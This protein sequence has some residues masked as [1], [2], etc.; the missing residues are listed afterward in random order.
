[1]TYAPPTWKY[2]VDAHLLKVQRLQK[3]VLRATGNLDMCTL[4]CELHVAFKIPKL[5]RTQAEV[6]INI[7]NQTYVVLEKEKSC[8]GGITSLNL[9]AVKLTTVQLTICSFR[10]VS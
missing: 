8:I 2:A 4:V 7:V 10:V 5:C 3:R 1:M 6:I 9:V